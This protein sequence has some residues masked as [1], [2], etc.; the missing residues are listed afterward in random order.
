MIE[1]D[2]IKIAPLCSNGYH[3][4]QLIGST[5]EASLKVNWLEL[6]HISFT[7]PNQLQNPL[8]NLTRV[9]SQ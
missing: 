6:C 3:V 9:L 7:D 1:V 2:E 8:N 5:G 4:D